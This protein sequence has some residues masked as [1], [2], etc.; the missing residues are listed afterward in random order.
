MRQFIDKALAR[1]AVRDKLA[2]RRMDI[3]ASTPECLAKFVN[4]E[5]ERWGKMVHDNKIRAGE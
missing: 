2:Q 4:G 5:M 3:V 1:P